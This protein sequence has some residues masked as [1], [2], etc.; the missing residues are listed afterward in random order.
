[1]S[2]SRRTPQPSPAARSAR[3]APAEPVQIFEVSTLYGVATLAASLDAGQF[4]PPGAARRILLVSNNAATPEAATRLVTMNGFATLA[5]RFDEIIDWNEAIRPYHPS[6]W[7]PLRDESPMWERMF[8]NAWQLGSA[9][10]ELVVESVHVSPA[11]ALATIFSGSAIHVYADGLMSYGPTRERLPQ[12]LGCRIQRLLHLDLVPG[13]RPL[14]LAEHTVR[15]EIVPSDAFVKVLGELGEAAAGEPELARVAADRPTAVLLGQYLAALNILTPE[16]EEELHARM[17]RGAAAA[18]HE[19]VVFKPHPTAPARYSQVLEKAAAQEGVRL[20]ILRGPVLAEAVYD[21]CRPT[22]VVGCFSTALLTA[23][24]YYDI[25]IAKVGTESLLDRLTPYQ[26]SNRVPV[27]IVDFAVPDLEAV[28]EH[29]PTAPRQADE[30]AALV[31]TVG[32]CMQAKLHPLLR[33][34]AVQWLDAH[35]GEATARYF[36]RRRLTALA[37]PG[38]GT[39][40]RARLLRTSPSARWAARRIRAAQRALRQAG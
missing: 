33:E 34:D 6:T 31:R 23:A 30:L 3:P 15:P 8:R 36:K 20:H 27:T 7:S 9:P 13:L 18:G 26:N 29:T 21:R 24:A 22:L 39:S 5:Q 19:C 12:W 14:L 11:R 35:L 1:M 28:A 38:G 10:V 4:G 32:Y 37:L 25:P 16:E 17:L 2:E 40:V